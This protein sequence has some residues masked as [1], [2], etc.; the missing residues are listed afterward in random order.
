[1]YFCTK[2]FRVSN[3]S[4]SQRHSYMAKSQNEQP[5]V[6]DQLINSAKLAILSQTSDLP[7]LGK[8]P[9]LVQLQGSSAIARK[10]AAAVTQ[11]CVKTVD[12]K[13]MARGPQLLGKSIDSGKPS[14]PGQQP[15]LSFD[16]IEVETE[17]YQ[18]KIYNWQ[19]LQASQASNFTSYDHNNTRTAELSGN[20]ICL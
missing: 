1:M 20:Y 15:V 6:S 12:T 16:R 18:Q 3:R 19:K 11:Q 4:Q 9:S 13:R 5:Q 8:Q 10:P 17:S 7:N 14:F 2:Y